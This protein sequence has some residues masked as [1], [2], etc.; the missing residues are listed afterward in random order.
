MNI[1]PDPVNKINAAGQ[2]DANGSAGPGFA[3]IKFRSSY[4]T[5]V[6]RTISGR[7]V[8]ASPGF[9]N[10]EFDINYNP[11]T[12]AE[13]EPVMNFLEER[14]G[15]LKP[16]FVI[17]PQHS[18]PQDSTLAGNI[19]TASAN[20]EGSTV[21]NISGR[22][23]G[24]FTKGDFITF[25]DPADALHLKAYKVTAVLSSNSI[26]ISPPLVRSVSSGSTINYLNPKFR[27]IQKGD[28]LEYDLD[29]DNLYQFSLS[30]E[31]IQP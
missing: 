7:G 25:T 10:W 6:S 26:R 16:F 19:V 18:G 5:Q 3:K 20:A 29:T 12:R 11:L 22:T 31:E 28:V 15:R 2:A 24:S 9:H 13:F 4:Q 27:V 23:A 30:L 17:L 14:Q 8:Q 1:L 21:I